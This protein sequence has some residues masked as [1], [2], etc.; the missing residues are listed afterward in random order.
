MNKIRS[1]LFFA[2]IGLTALIPSAAYTASTDGDL[3]LTVVAQTDSTITF[4][5]SAAADA[6]GYKYYVG[7][8][9]SSGNVTYTTVSRTFDPTRLTVKFGKG[10]EAFRVSIQ[11]VT[12]RT[13][14]YS[15]LLQAQCNDTRDN[16]A[17]E[18][19]DYPNDPGCDRRNDNDE[20]NAPPPDTQP[21]TTPTASVSNVNDSGATLNW[22]ASTDNVGVDHYDVYN[23]MSVVG[24]T[25]S[26]SYVYN[27]LSC[28]TN[29]V[30]GVQAVDAAGNKSGF[31]TSNVTTSSCPTS[32]ST[33]NLFVDTDGGSCTYFA[34]A[35]AYS[36][37]QACGDL[38]SA[39]QKAAPG[40]KIIVEGGKYPYVTL[41]Y[42]SSLQNL[43]PGCN[44]YGEWG[45][46]STSKCIEIVANGDV[47]FRGLTN[48]ASSVWMHGNVTGGEL[49]TGS[50]AAFKARSYN[51]HITN[52]DLIGN[53][54][55]GADQDANCN[56]KSSNFQLARNVTTTDRSKRPDHVVFSG[57]DSDTASTYGAS[58][59]LLRNADVGPMWDDTPNRGS[60]SGS[61][62]DV[63][64]IWNQGLAGS[65]DHVVW[66][67]VFVHEVNRTMWCDINNACH[68]D[69]LY[70][71][72]GEGITLRNI[73]MS[74]VTGV[75]LFF[76]H[77]SSDTYGSHNVT[78][79]NSWFGCL[80]NSYPDSPSTARTTCGG[81]VPFSIK[82]CGYNGC[83]NWLVRYNSWYAI[84]AAQTSYTN[85]RFVGNAG[86]QP[87]GSS[88][89][90]TAV[91]WTYNA[92]YT[93][94][95]GSNCGT[96]NVNT[97]SSS[98]GSLFV[99][100]S[101]GQENFHLSGANGSTAADNLVPSST[102]ANLNSDFDGQT[103]PIGT[104]RDAG[105]DER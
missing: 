30:L 92:F 37:S 4:K 63:P 14:G 25:T 24:Q 84:S 40:N 90:C 86:K 18:L 81:G 42:R 21:P 65:P 47:T 32:T 77:F 101:P 82:N 22:T 98:P 5:Y 60:S 16:D 61:G 36:S 19:I 58:Y 50:V 72:D 76:E 3:D 8:Y 55:A 44:P 66:D 57:I 102:D 33:A 27:S 91:S 1:I 94:S 68:P 64:R 99:N 87:S 2:V 70:V 6:E 69:G 26:L 29:Y 45:T 96:T 73:G 51:L 83:V 20:Y 39:F 104:K 97:G 41:A 93:T 23:G 88:A 74:Q 46:P 56:C 10:P 79:E 53:P 105:A 15:Y 38:N 9:D 62:P 11:D 78:I 52:S 80:V 48:Q 75:G 95:G 13:D 100:V 54:P 7:A 103:R 31:E 34:T 85:V 28:G 49:G 35:T 67:S 12:E 71:T 89:L 17:D 43:S 59:V